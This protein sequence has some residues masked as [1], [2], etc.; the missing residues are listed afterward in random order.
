MACEAM[1]AFVSAQLKPIFETVHFITVHYCHAAMKTRQAEYKPSEAP[2]EETKAKGKRKIG[3]PKKSKTGTGMRAGRMKNNIL[4]RAATPQ[5]QSSSHLMR[6]HVWAGE[7]HKGE[8]KRAALQ[9][10]TEKAD[11]SPSKTPEKRQSPASPTGK[12]P[13][14][15]AARVT[16]PSSPQGPTVPQPPAPA[17][18]SVRRA[19]QAPQQPAGAVLTHTA[20][21]K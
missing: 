14:A 4:F 18:P 16:S 10:K 21:L 17:S 7:L 15:K 19:R 12:S 8:K 20:V 2:E 5:T 1:H 11:A 6:F 3:R 9:A 13:V